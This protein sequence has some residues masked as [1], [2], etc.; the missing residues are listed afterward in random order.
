MHHDQWVVMSFLWKTHLI[1]S[2]HTDNK[3]VLP[4]SNK[5]MWDVLQ[6]WIL[7]TGNW[8]MKMKLHQRKR[9]GNT[10]NISQVGHWWNYRRNSWPWNYWY[11][12]LQEPWD[13]YQEQVSKGELRNINEQS[14]CEWR[15]SRWSNAVRHFTLR[16]SW[17]YIDTTKSNILEDDPNLERNMT[18][19]MEMMLAPYR[20]FEQTPGQGK[21][22]AAVHGIPKS[23]TRH[24]DW[25][26]TAWWEES[27]H[28]SIYSW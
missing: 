12:F 22:C 27:K 9:S 15:C 10:G 28:W 7:S 11:L 6:K 25:T 3:V 19:C 16:N 20:R 23:W 17:R 21:L 2:S 8:P 14:G 13:T 26:T 18:I 24:S 5:P 4:L 1:L